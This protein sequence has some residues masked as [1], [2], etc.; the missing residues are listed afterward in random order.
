MPGRRFGGLV[1]AAVLSSAAPAAARDLALLD[2]TVVD[3]LHGGTTPHRNVLIRD[4]RILTIGVDSPP[5]DAE[6]VPASGKFVIPGL[7]DMVTHVSWTRGSALPA[8][9]ANGVTAIRDEGGDLA[10]T[11]IWADGVR[12]GLIDGPTIFQSGPMLNGRSFN[13]YQYPLGTPEAA[14]DAVRLLAFERV[15][16]LEIERRVPRAVYA[17]LMQ[18]AKAR[19]LP[20][21]GK[22]PIE[23]TPEEVADAGQATIDNIETLYD[24]RFA[25]AHADDVAGGIKAFLRP[26]GD[27]GALFAAMARDGTATTPCLIAF[28]RAIANTGAADP[29]LRYVARSQRPPPPSPAPS[30]PATELAMFRAMLP[31]LLATVGRM[32]QAGVVVL[33]GTDI[34]TDRI[35]GFSL[36]DEL[37]LL[38]RAG[39][40]PLEVLQA[41]TLNPARVMK[42]LSDYG[43][44]APGRIADLVMLDGDPS[45][46]PAALH[47]IAAVV[48]HGRLR[49]RPR[50]DALLRQAEAEAAAD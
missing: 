31:E 50:L 6:V 11:A 37:D 8:L 29:R 7:W 45:R 4:G 17:A 15:D 19:H 30:L 18:E 39:L 47:R 21:G 43:T 32:Q 36:H 9:A 22:V 24:G 44:V 42:R 38:A 2:V 25:A 35:P 34:A 41:A 12:R 33:A 28:A 14:R 27:G 23:M 1:L 5:Q 10:E 26:D 48:L 13:R 16:G 20:I 40:T 3:T 49:D 46:D